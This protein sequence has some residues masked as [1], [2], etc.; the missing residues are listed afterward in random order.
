MYYL[1]IVQNTTTIASYV[2]SDYDT[3]LAAF[4]QELA[5]RAEGRTHTMC[6]IIDLRGSVVKTGFYDANEN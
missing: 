1:I 4:H 3:A 5:Y 2:Y 6:V